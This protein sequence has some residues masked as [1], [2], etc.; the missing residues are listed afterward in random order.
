M[1]TGNKKQREAQ[2]DWEDKIIRAKKVR[3]A[4][5][6]LMKVDLAV[7]YFDGRQRPPN[8]P[9]DEWI[10]INKVYSS[11]KATLPS[12]YSAD[13][14]FYVRLKRSFK[15]DPEIIAEY[16]Q[17]GKIRQAML[18]Y[19]KEALSLKTKTRM[20]IQDAQFS[21]GAA[22]VHYEAD[23]VEN[24]K[25]G[26]PIFGENDEPLVDQETGEGLVEPDK[27]PVDGKYKITRIH[28]DD[29]LWD[30]DAGPLED[31][32]TWL[33]QRIREPWDE[34]K[35]NPRYSKKGLKSVKEKG[36]GEVK[37]DEEKVREDRKKGGDVLGVSERTPKN[38]N[39]DL[40]EPEMLI[41]W[42]I[43]NLRKGTWLI[44]AENG[45]I[46]LMDEEDIPLGIDKHPFSILRFTM[47]DDSPY[48]IPPMSQ[49]ILVQKE[50]NMSRSDI[51]KH[52]KRFNRK[53]EV[54][55]S[56]ISD[57]SELSKLESGDDGTFILVQAQG[58]IGPIKDAPM[59]QGRYMEL[60]Y[61][62]ADMRELFGGV[63][64]EAK[65]IAG[66]DTATQAGILDKRLEV[67]EGDAMSMV[68]DFTKTIARKLDL[69]V[70]VNLSED[71][72]VKVHGPEGEYWEIVR[73]K[74]YEE[75]EG[76]YQYDVNVGST[77]PRMPQMERA[78][79]QAFLGMLT[80][81]PQLLLSPRLLKNMAE[82]HH[83]EDE[84]MINELMDIGKKMMSGQI[85]ASGNVG[86]QPG[87][88]EDRPVSA[89]GGQ[90]GGASNPVEGA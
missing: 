47:R 64:D 2:Q 56:Q 65:G 22:K 32:W 89:I 70:Q 29:F 67:K 36:G 44:I 59:D 69:L 11:L 27:I 23:E 71:E 6:V 9:E 28:P 60:G 8:Y 10:T 15:P 13:P 78:S 25:A 76:E 54:I 24:E 20:S 40:G 43:Y 51:V 34:A 5:K 48:P 12:L 83:I 82:Q 33:A 62:N 61:M 81:F 75:I 19:L 45:E 35:K 17:K 90:V 16:E 21:Y 80:N 68:I 55:E 73:E 53:Y 18:N 63:S 58:A 85:P 42:E 37:D 87:V 1:A 79:W 41:A 57:K 38:E 84:S 66:A 86:S 49:G 52:R 77:L 31:E 3:A 30:E 46:P 72:A 50:Y 26:E 14:Y 7:E 39:K 4:W 88:G 74:D